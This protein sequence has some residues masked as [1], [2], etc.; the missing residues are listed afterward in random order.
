MVMGMMSTQPLR[1]GKK[2]VMRKITVLLA[3][4][5]LL[6]TATAALAR[7]GQSADDCPPGSTDPDCKSSTK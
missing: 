1:N 6:L 4:L 7:G 3:M 2:Q 5:M